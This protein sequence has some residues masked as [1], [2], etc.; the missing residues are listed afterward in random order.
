MVDKK[1]VGLIDV[2][3]KKAE[4][5]G[6]AATDTV[7]ELQ[8][9]TDNVVV[10]LVALTAQEILRNTQHNLTLHVTS[11]TTTTSTSTEWPFLPDN[12]GKPAPTVIM[13]GS[14]ISCTICKSFA[15]CSRQ[16]TATA[17]YTQFLQVRCSS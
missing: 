12:L 15:P 16:I 13:G 4:A 2:K 5:A 1:C 11:L 7:Q 3:A 8:R 9:L 14:G 6:R 10:G 17:S